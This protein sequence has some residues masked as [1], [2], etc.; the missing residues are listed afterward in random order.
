[1]ATGSSL[2]PKLSVSDVPA[3]EA[4]T[5]KAVGV[6]GEVQQR[7]ISNGY[8]RVEVP[9]DYVDPETGKDS[10]FTA[11]FNVRPEWFEPTFKDR[12]STLTDSE[13]VQYNINMQGL[14]RGLFTSAGLSEMDF[15]LLQGQ[16]VGFKTK[17]RKDD[18]SF[19]DISFFFKPNN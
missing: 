9:L 7:A 1:M 11:R 5:V 16:R 6:I 15:G 4:K 19:T 2:L 14:T 10:K 12:L 18:P 17:L 3:K 13:Q 8:V